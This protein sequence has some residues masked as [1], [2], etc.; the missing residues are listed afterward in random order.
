MKKGIFLLFCIF[1]YFFHISS[2]DAK[3][4]SGKCIYNNSTDTTMKKIELEFSL[5]NGNDTFT[6]YI[7]PSWQSHGDATAQSITLE[8][9]STV[10][11]KF[12]NEN[13]VCP[14]Y[15]ITAVG[16]WFHNRVHKY[17][18][19]YSNEEYDQV[20]EENKKW[21]SKFYTTYFVNYEEVD[22]G[23]KPDGNPAREYKKQYYPSLTSSA[24]LGDLTFTLIYD[25]VNAVMKQ[26]KL[27]FTKHSGSV[28][29]ISS[30][31]IA[32]FQKNVL[33][34]IVEKGTYPKEFWCGTIRAYF[35][36]GTG[37]NFMLGGSAQ[38]GDAVCSLEKNLFLDSNASI[39]HYKDVREK[40]STGGSTTIPEENP[41]PITKPSIPSNTEPTEPIEPS[42]NNITMGQVCRNTN[43]KVVLKYIGWLLSAARLIIP[44][45]LIVLGV[46]DFIKAVTSQKPE[47]LTKAMKTL[48]MRG[49]AGVV[50]FFVPVLVHFVFTLVD[51]WSQYKTAYSECTVCLTNPS[52]C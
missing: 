37:A 18:A 39:I 25:E 42:I 14:S 51:D 34:P 12:R 41:D 26:Q 20:Q 46:L 29:W 13:H 50:I 28:K 10:S 47:E 1:V 19:V 5:V 48:L 17:F 24:E 7:K 40:P 35:N 21:V 23:A 43:L 2:I 32:G 52:K 44:I 8:N 22:D 15:I 11:Y 16:N 38:A 30:Y 9:G 49:I 45:I 27:S 33:D 6:A 31:D 3:I 36:I 4:T